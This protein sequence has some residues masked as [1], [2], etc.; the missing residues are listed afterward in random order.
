MFLLTFATL[1]LLGAA[2]PVLA[3]PAD[4]ERA[5]REAAELRAQVERL[6]TRLEKACEDLAFAKVELARV[7]N[8]LAHNETVLAQAEMDLE[9]ASDR[10]QARVRGMYMDGSSTM[11]EAVLTSS[12]LTEFM[13]RLE[14]LA[15]IGRQDGE[16]FEQVAAFRTKIDEK[17]D[18]LAEQRAA[19]TRLVAETE[20]AQAEI[21]RGLKAREEALRGKEAQVAQ[22]QREEEQRQARLLA[23]AQEAARRQA[24]QEAA[25][26]EAAT[27]EAASR[28]NQRSESTAT[29]AS[30]GP[31]ASN[32]GSPGSGASGGSGSSTSGSSAS[33]G[34]SN[35]SRPA[36][37]PSRVGGSVIDIALSYVGVPYK[38]GGS[39][40]AG[41][42]CSGFTMFVFAKVGVS[43]PHSSRAQFSYGQPVSRSDLRPGDLVF[44]GSPI[45]HVGIYVG[46]GNMVHSPNTG[47]SVR[48]NSMDRRDYAGA[49]RVG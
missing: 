12:S 16:V 32:S 22:L 17:K 20:K 8:E 9:K 48:V 27:R 18:V 19:Q 41:F 7:E 30:S 35:A 49:R 31:G 4:I 36:P 26:R 24:A 1:L 42:D 34:D 33:R 23:E 44:F 43:L 25:S 46:G 38:W 5:K 21:E 29:T 6:D 28:G 3:S 39:T 2:V 37:A 45:H 13:N 47:S 15:R 11:L 14:F 40:P 10:L